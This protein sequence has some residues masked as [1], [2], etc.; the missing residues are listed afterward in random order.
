DAPDAEP[1]FCG[2]MSLSTTLV[3]W[4]VA[5]PTQ[6]P[7][8]ISAG[9][10][11]Q[12]SVFGPKAAVYIQMPV[13]SSTR[14]TVITYFGPNRWLSAPPMPPPMNAAAPAGSNPGPTGR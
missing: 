6:I 3:S 10:N 2:G 1:A 11:D 4:L 13:A 9:N 12:K 7:G 8:R 5:K 14:P